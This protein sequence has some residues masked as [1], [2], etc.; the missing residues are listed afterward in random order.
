[1]NSKDPQNIC[2]KLPTN[3]KAIIP[4]CSQMRMRNARSIKSLHWDWRTM[5][6]L[7]EKSVQSLSPN[8][9]ENIAT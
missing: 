5:N 4:E 9:S 3:L 1:M 8:N 6:G 7:P 2:G